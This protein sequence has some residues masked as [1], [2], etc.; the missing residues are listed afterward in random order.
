MKFGLW[1]IDV[2]GILLENM[3]LWTLEKT[4]SMKTCWETFNKVW[5]KC[6]G[7]TLKRWRRTGSTF[8]GFQGNLHENEVCVGIWGDFCVFSEIFLTFF[9]N[10]KVLNTKKQIKYGQKISSINL[11]KLRLTMIL[12]TNFYVLEQLQ[13]I[14]LILEKFQVT[15]V[16]H[17]IKVA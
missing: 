1:K 2:K 5:G 14:K 10:W 12:R 15:S 6:V 7:K 4:F 8:W 16:F 9:R 13:N 17:R 3:L 11:I